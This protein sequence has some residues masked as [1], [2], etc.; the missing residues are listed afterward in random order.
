MTAR[1]T[2]AKRAVDRA[3]LMLNTAFSPW[4]SPGSPCCCCEPQHQ[5]GN[6]VV[7]A[8]DLLTGAHPAETLPATTCQSRGGC[9]SWH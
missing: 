1:L 3:W 4:P 5:A 7:Q 8:P 2:A 6:C 9:V